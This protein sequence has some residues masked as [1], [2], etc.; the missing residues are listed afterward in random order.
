MACSQF[1]KWGIDS[2]VEICSV[3]SLHLHGRHY[4]FIESVNRP[5]KKKKHK[6]WVLL[7]IQ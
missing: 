3:I 7:K 2:N 5:Y 1:E 4:K 6:F